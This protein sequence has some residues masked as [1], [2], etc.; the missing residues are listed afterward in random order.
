M[1]RSRSLAAVGAM[2]AVIAVAAVARGET[3]PGIIC[4]VAAIG[5]ALR[6]HSEWKREQA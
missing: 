1:S 2:F 5:C 3:V 6:A 4:I